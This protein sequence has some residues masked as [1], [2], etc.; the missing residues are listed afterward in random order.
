M[1]SFLGYKKW[2][3]AFKPTSILCFTWVKLR[4]DQVDKAECRNDSR[5]SNKYDS[6]NQKR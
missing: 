6:N 2:K 4:P 1:P 3:Q 5:H